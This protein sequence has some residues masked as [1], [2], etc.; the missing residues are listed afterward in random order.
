M[1]KRWKVALTAVALCTPVAVLIP[2]AA[3]VV[4]TKKVSK[5]KED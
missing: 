1:K 4:I 2:V 3:A 5:K